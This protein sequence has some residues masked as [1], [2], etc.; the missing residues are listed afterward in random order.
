[1][2]FSEKKSMGFSNR[3]I[4]ARLALGFGCVLAITLVIGLVGIYMTSLFRDRVAHL[5]ANNT[6]GA[7]Y[8]ADAQSALWQLRWDVAQFIAVQ[9]T[10]VR[11]KLVENGPVQQKIVEENLASFAATERTPEELATLEQIRK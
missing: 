1:M 2:L 10:G 8:L 5:G 3:R 7:A 6:R 4:G 11:K 9:E